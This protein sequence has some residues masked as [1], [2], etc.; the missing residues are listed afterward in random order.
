LLLRPFT[1]SLQGRYLEIKSFYHSLQ[2]SHTELRENYLQG[3]AEAIVLQRRPYL[4]KKEQANALTSL[5]ADQVQRLIKR[6][7]RRRM[8]RMVA[9]VLTDLESGKRGIN[10]IDIPTSTTDEPYPIGPDPKTWKG[11]WKSI[12]DQ[13]I[14]LKHILAAN[15]RQ[16]NEAEL[17]LI[18]G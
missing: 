13:S 5:T 6:E 15:V 9:N 12:T 2:K 10:R 1:L 7:K 17:T 14:I 11:P 16:Y 3:L 8:F 4:Q 18:A